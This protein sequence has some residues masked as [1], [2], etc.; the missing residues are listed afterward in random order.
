MVKKRFN[1]LELTS[2]LDKKETVLIGFKNKL[3]F[4]SNSY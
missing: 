2:K 4:I 1:V 3:Y